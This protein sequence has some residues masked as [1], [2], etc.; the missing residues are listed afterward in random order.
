MSKD[1]F[2]NKLNFLG[3]LIDH[4]NLT[5]NHIELPDSM[6]ESFT[7]VIDYY[8]SI[9]DSID[10]ELTELINQEEPYWKELYLEENHIKYISGDKNYETHRI[11]IVASK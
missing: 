1:E 11:C 6:K 9:Y 7:N 10:Q 2:K 4:L 8:S 5:L 3:D